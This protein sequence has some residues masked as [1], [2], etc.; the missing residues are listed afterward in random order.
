MS[1]AVIASLGVYCIQREMLSHYI[2]TRSS[3]T[4]NMYYI[5]PCSN[6]QERSGHSHHSHTLGLRAYSRQRVARIL[7]PTHH[8]NIRVEVLLALCECLSSECLRDFLNCRK[9]IESCY[10]YS[11]H[12][13]YTLHCPVVDASR[14]G[15]SPSWNRKLVNNKFSVQLIRAPNTLSQIGEGR[16]NVVIWFYFKI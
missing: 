9:K 6:C 11:T 5:H 8:T 12:V 3:L 14:R 16:T 2:S 10:T 7:L 1:Q 15:W 13:V 4:W